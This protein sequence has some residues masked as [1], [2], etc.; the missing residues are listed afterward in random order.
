MLFYSRAARWLGWTIFAA[1]AGLFFGLPLVMLVLASVARQWNDVLPSQ[2]GLGN[3]LSAVRGPLGRSLLT[4]LLTA[5]AATAAA[6]ALGAWGALAARSLRGTV[7]RILDGIYAAPVALP[8]VTIGLA[9]LVTFSRPPV[10]LNGT[11]VPVILAHVILVTAYAYSSTLA[12]LAQLPESL[13]QVAFSL[14]GSRAYVLRRVTLPLLRPYLAAAAS[15]SFAFSM[16]ELGA[17]VMV[18]PPGWVTAPVEVYALT[19]RGSVFSGAAVSVLLLGATVTALI[20]FSRIGRRRQS[21]F[22]SRQILTDHIPMR[23]RHAENRYQ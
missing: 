4:S 23:R 5:L 21:S 13:E 11:P 6:V 8:T 12:G 14:G 10:V 17:T 7:R 19:N 1:T 15:L 2:W 22:H 9:L 3:L 20:F 16:G 18:Y